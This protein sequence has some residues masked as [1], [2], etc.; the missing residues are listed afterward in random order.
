[1]GSPR[2]IPGTLE[3]D[4]SP[5]DLT[6][7]EELP[8]PAIDSTFVL[9][10]RFTTLAGATSFSTLPMDVSAYGGAQFQVWRGPFRVKSDTPAKS[11]KIYLE[12]SLDTQTWVLGPDTP[13][14]ITI[15]EGEVKLFSYDFRLRWFRLRV[16]IA[17]DA[18]IVT[19]WA[20]G[21]LRGGGGGQWQFGGMPTGNIDVG[22]RSG[23][24][25]RPAPA[26]FVWGRN[27][28]GGDAL[29]RNEDE[30]GRQANDW[31]IGQGIDPNNLSR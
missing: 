13:A 31:L 20:E 24:P 21:L 14:A 26:G 19:C 10:P 3:D 9:L 30:Q 4:V 11:F 15:A 16:E 17:G 23:S 22:S 7:Q 25:I 6:I 1:M 27:R 18:P 5:T 29:Y 12:E 8:M 2:P 28:F